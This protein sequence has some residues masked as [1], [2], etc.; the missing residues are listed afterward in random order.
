MPGALVKEKEAG[1]DLEPV[2]EKM[3]ALAQKYKDTST[4]LYCAKQGM[5]DEVVKL[6]DLRHYMQSFAGAAYQNPKSIC[7]QHQMILPELYAIMRQQR[8]RNRS[9]VMR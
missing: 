6:A 9:W 4:P 1:R 5:V 3:N 7:P 8:K 2:V